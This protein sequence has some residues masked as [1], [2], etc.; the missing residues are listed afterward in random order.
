LLASLEVF[1][2]E[3]VSLVF[4]FIELIIATS[5]IFTTSITTVVCDLKY[6]VHCVY[7][8]LILN[9]INYAMLVK[10]DFEVV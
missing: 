10:I 2:D 1:S 5:S 3:C 4:S 9:E 8:K 6:F 7:V